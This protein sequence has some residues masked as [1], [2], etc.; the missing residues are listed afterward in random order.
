MEVVYIWLVMVNTSL[1]RLFTTLKPTLRDDS[2]TLKKRDENKSGGSE[3][4]TF[5]MTTSRS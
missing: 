4:G 2:K 1:R 5:G 3:K